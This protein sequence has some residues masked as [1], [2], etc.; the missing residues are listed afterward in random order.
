MDLKKNYSK[1]ISDAKNPNQGVGGQ[2]ELW[3]AEF[4]TKILVENGLLPDH[5]LLELGCGTGRLL[6]GLSRFSGQDFKY[7]GIDLVDDLI[8]LTEKRIENLG[9][10]SSSFKTRK[11]KNELDYPSGAKFDFMCAFSVYT[12][13]EPEDIFNSLVKLRHVAH[14]Q[15]IA[16]VTFL[17]LENEFGKVNFL[18]ESNKR[19][20]SRYGVVRNVAMTKSQ[21][22]KIA[23]LAGWKTINSNWD[24]LDDPYE[25]G[26]IRTNQSWLILTP[27]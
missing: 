13:M 3:V 24:E 9:L 10:S 7:L 2:D 4:Q 27:E 19:L 16:L 12:H 18:Q 15:T 11:M 23:S 22:I 20:D 6:L 25:N 21:A 17:P 8:G 5:S 26:I 1:H 14:Q